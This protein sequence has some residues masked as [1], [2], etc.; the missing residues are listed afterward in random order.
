M[1]KILYTTFLSLTL[2]LTA[3]NGLAMP[4]E[5]KTTTLQDQKQVKITI[6]NENL[7]LIKDLRHVSLDKGINRLAW[8]EVSAQMRPETALLRIP[9][10]PAGFRLLEQN[11]DFD[12]LTP[13]KLLEKYLGQV[14]TLIH[15][16]PATGEETR[17]AATVLSTN[18]GVVLKFDDR[19]E[20]GLPGRLAFPGVPNHLRDR[21][22]LS[23]VL[24]DALPGEHELELSYLTSGLSWHADYVAE[25]DASDSRLD[26]SGLVTLANRSGIA[27]HNAHL[28]LVAGDINQIRPD[29]Y[30]TGKVMAMA[31]E[32]ADY[33][34]VKEESLFEYHLYT[35]PIPT[36]L[37]ENQTKQVALM[38]ATGIPVSKEFLLRGTDVYYSRKYV[39][40]GDKLKPSVFIQFENKGD[41]LGVPLPK[42]T[43]RVYK[44]D[45]RDNA[46]FVGED[47][48]DHTARNESV[49]IKLGKAFDVTAER[50]QT[51]FQQ[52]A[53]TPQPLIETAHQIEIR[54]ARQEAVTVRVQ[55]PIPG[56]WTIISESQPHTKPSANV[57]EWPVTIPAN[58]KTVL[59][60]RVRI[61]Y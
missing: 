21:P 59:T 18:D 55:E 15:V 60:Y 56:D 16:N 41:D 6:Y 35:L 39:N 53:T 24:T 8:R 25:L 30:R 50:T 31:V 52:L 20:T 43:I 40:I 49:R 34:E 28:Q 61:R 3:F 4:S 14:I 45:S 1:Q 27:Y 36:T 47:R 12:L 33:Q 23:L 51:D 10:Q 19:I 44:N 11:F 54:N 13:Q 22:T 37:A 32:T 57:A 48:I 29:L 58:E 46:Q 7:A 17:E 9:A 2:S 5:E 26:L 38:S 42:G